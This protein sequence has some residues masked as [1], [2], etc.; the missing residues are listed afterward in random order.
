MSIERRL[1]KLEAKTTGAE[2]WETPMYV[3]VY[4]K[5]LENHRREE[6]GEAPIPLTPEEER[7]ER[8][9]EKDP[10]WRA[11]WQKIDRQIE[12]YEFE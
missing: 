9:T 11:Y 5:H 1:E 7:Y 6:A 3:R 4:I 12:G 2:T 10:A 8:E